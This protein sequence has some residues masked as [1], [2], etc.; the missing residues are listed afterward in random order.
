MTSPMSPEEREAEIRAAMDKERKRKADLRRKPKID[1]VQRMRQMNEERK[2][3]TREARRRR[4]LGLPAHGSEGAFELRQTKVHNPMAVPVDPD[5]SPE[6]QEAERR[7]VQFV[8][9]ARNV[10]HDVLEYEF[11]CKRINEVERAAGDRLAA[12]IATA[13]I[14][15]ARAISYE[16]PKV[17]GG[18]PGDPLTDDVMAAHQRLS[19]IRAKI[20]EADYVLLVMTI[21]EGKTIKAIAE[22]WYT[23]RSYRPDGRSAAAYI[24]CRFRD[25]LASLARIMGIAAARGPAEQPTKVWRGHTPLHFGP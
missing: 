22:A 12:L 19:D 25:A 17:D 3:E 8:T 21:G 2:A 11:A 7:R 10:R 14:G 15:G 20:G 6:D 4:K 23:D 1:P 13:G 9:V 16:K 18:L 5:K 24:A